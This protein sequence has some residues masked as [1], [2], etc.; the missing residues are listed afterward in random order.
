MKKLLIVNDSQLG[1]SPLYV[2]ICKYLNYDY[3]ITYICLDRGKSRIC[4][5]NINVI[6]VKKKSKFITQFK[7]FIVIYKMIKIKFDMV[8]LKTYT[9]GWFLRIV[10][11]KQ[12]FIYDIRSGSVSANIRKRFLQ[13][14]LIKF[15]CLFFKNITIISENLRKN[16]G[17]KMSKTFIAPL[18]ADI[19]SDKNKKF[20]NMR[21]I[22]IGTLDN[23]N[24]DIMLNGFI[25]F[26]KE[27]NNSLNINLTII[28]SGNERNKLEAIV[29]TNNL[30]KIV[31]FKGFIHHKNLKSYLDEANFG[32]S[33]IP[34]TDYYDCQPP[35][36]TFEYLLSGLAIL[37]TATSENKILINKSNGVLVN[38]N[39]NDIYHGF[40]KL[41]QNMKEYN[42]ENI[43]KAAE[44]HTWQYIIENIREYFISLN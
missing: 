30:E 23:R 41:S 31:I 32:L 39:V 13:D 2:Y 44:Q 22:Y 3:K 16:L 40:V 18:G 42:S 34:M 24:L 43:R 7:Y 10:F 20:D 9:L 25:K 35:T 21:V 12:L 11:P 4:F 6:Y 1:Y 29:K 17:I 19:L 38:D 37:A 27:F 36:K 14:L 33:F 26:Y 5:E 15:N 28:G 8:I